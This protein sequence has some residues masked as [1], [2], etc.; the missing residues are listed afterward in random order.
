MKESLELF[1][2]KGKTTGSKEGD[3]VEGLGNETIIKTEKAM[4]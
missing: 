2:D 4:T 3:R 1:R